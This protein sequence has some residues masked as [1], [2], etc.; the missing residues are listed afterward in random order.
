[1]TISN[2]CPCLPTVHNRSCFSNNY[3]FKFGSTPLLLELKIQFPGSVA[4]TEWYI[5]KV[6]PNLNPFYHRDAI[7]FTITPYCKLIV[8]GKRLAN[9]AQ[10]I[11]TYQSPFSLHPLQENVSLYT[12]R[13]FI[14]FK[15]IMN[16]RKKKRKNKIGV[17]CHWLDNAKRKT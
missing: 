10:Y 16:R 15:L 11:S 13:H 5:N 3:A 12:L 6:D 1:M 4:S 14:H 7:L 17:I 8:H 9:T 2:M